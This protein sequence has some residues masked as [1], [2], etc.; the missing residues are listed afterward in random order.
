MGL[1]LGSIRRGDGIDNGLG[2]LVADLLVVVD[3]VADVVATGVVGF[4]HAHR[5]VCQVDIAIVAKD[6]WR[7][8]KEVSFA[9]RVNKLEGVRHRIALHLGILTAV[10]R[11]Q[12]E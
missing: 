3:D 12:Q 7:E 5:V 2:L 9:D 6:W 1:T 10:G 4:A 8:K 11:I